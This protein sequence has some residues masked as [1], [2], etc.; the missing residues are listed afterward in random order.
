[1][2]DAEFLE[3][4]FQEYLDRCADS[5]DL[6][7]NGITLP[8]AH[9]PQLVYD[10][11]APHQA[12]VFSKLTP[13]LEDLQVGKTPKRRKFW[14]ER[15]KKASKDSDISLCLLW[16]LAF[17]KKPIYLQVGAAD[18]DQAAIVRSR[19]EETIY[20]NP[21]LNDYLKVSNYKAVSKNGPAE[22]DILAA[23]VA[24]SHGGTPDLLVCNEMSHVTKW[25]F[26]E[27]LLD[28]AAGVPR[29]VVIIATN[30][31]HKGTKVWKLREEC[32]KSELWEFQSYARPAPWLSQD[33]IEEAKKRNL[34]SRYKRLYEG[35]WASGKGDAFDDG[36]IDGSF[37][38]NLKELTQPEP[39]WQYLAGLD[40][41]IKHD[42]SG[43]VVIGIHQKEKRIRLATMRG[44]APDQATGK[45]DLTQVRSYCLRL[46]K[47]FRICWFGF[48]PYQAELMAQ[49]LTKENV[50][51]RE[52]SFTG[53]NLDQMAISLMGVLQQGIF[54]SYEDH[55][56]RLRQDLAKFNIVEKSYGYKLESVRDEDGHADVG[57]ALAI[58]LPQA[59]KMLGLRGILMEDDELGNPLDEPLSEEE[60][61]EMPEVLRDIFEMEPGIKPKRV[62]LDG[63]EIRPDDYLD[64]YR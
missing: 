4:G 35:V 38:P 3:A 16:L 20:Y 37:K 62:R 44:F 14:I 51:M 63:T 27:N 15:T 22:L 8:S 23:D 29:G 21:W 64:F 49:D 39:G 57:T 43:V 59:C 13:T 54:E 48:D 55:E 47:T 58:C 46:A 26:I 19:M 25:E 42:H 33:D 6:F 18:K 11:L 52:V 50:P 34:P 28:N 53:K 24:G 2:D 12:Q 40:L 9:G 10:I 60:I 56:G 31:G 32:R 7:L 5:F 41:G 36:W 17:P 45:I 61:E 1:M 30:A